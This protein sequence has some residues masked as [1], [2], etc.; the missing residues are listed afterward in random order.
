[1][2]LQIMGAN[3]SLRRAIV[4]GFVGLL[5]FGISV[6]SWGEPSEKKVVRRI[7]S[8]EELETYSKKSGNI[9][10]MT[11]GVYRLIDHIPLER[12]AERR[13][14]KQFQFLDFTGSDNQFLL[15]GVTLEVDTRLREALR[16]PI[17]NP[18]FRISGNRNWVSGLTLTNIGDGTSPAGNVLTIAGDGVTLEKCTI[19]VR[20]SYPYGY[21]DFFGKGGKPLIGH[22]KHSGVQILGNKSRILGCALFLRSFGHGFYIQGGSK[23][24]FEDCVV[25]GE[26]RKTESMLAETSGPAFRLDFQAEMTNREGTRRILPGYMKSLAEDGYRTYAGIQEVHL[27]RCTARNMRGGFEL[28]TK[29]GG[30]RLE[31]CT[32]TGNERG[33]WLGG[34]ALAER[35]KGDAEFGPL[36]FLDGDRI[37]V[38]LE[39]MPTSSDRVVHALATIQGDG[40]DV[41][42]RPWKKLERASPLPILVGFA[43]PA[44]G[45]GAAPYR[46][47][48][49]RGVK[50]R[51]ET[52]MP[53]S[54]SDQA[55]DCQIVSRG[56]VTENAGQ[57]IRVES[58]PE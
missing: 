52:R 30:V 35:C 5:A 41:S 6:Q 48:R 15:E 57:R 44:A 37:S 24:Y 21:G 14:A 27:V 49:A 23:H 18:E 36:L 46:V 43:Q 31:D 12:I 13:A 56:A 38:D 2:K 58:L 53:V 16:A 47:Q 1:M 51:N 54:V 26:M 10:R 4:C 8:L 28:R 3:R 7:S 9:V 29:N 50:L 34:G 33:F 32:A 40:H 42:L 22:R 39:V 19:H 25:E 11:P 55:A 20:G 45:E 17:H